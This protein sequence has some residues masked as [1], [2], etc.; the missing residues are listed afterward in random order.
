MVFVSSNGSAA[1]IDK[2]GNIIIPLKQITSISKFYEN[3]PISGDALSKWGK[4]ISN[5]SSIVNTQQN[6]DSAKATIHDYAVLP[7]FILNRLS[8]LFMLTLQ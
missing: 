3:I 5:T 4:I 2:N 8:I 6:I 7:Y 1:V